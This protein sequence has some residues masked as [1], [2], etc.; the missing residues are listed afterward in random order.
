MCVLGMYYVR[1]KRIPRKSILYLAKVIFF[2]GSIIP[3]I[4]T[5]PWNWKSNSRC[6]EKQYIINIGQRC[7]EDWLQYLD[8][9]LLKKRGG[10]FES[11]RYNPLFVVMFRYA[12]SL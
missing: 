1:A 3:Y 9:G 12:E 5:K 6:C 2:V 4:F 10:R 7:V 8:H 11:K